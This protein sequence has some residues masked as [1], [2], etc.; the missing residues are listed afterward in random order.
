MKI[1][2][3]CTAEPYSFLVNDTTLPS[4]IPLR[5]RK[6][7][8]KNKYIIQSLPL[9]IRLRMKNYNMT[10]LQKLKKY[11]SDDQAKLISMNVLLVMK[12]YLQIKNKK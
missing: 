5:F 4:D 11:Q 9:M 3:I 12:Y 8:L 2:K 1:Y 6:K 7:S 10:L